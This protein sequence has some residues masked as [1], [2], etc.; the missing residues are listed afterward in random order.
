MFEPHGDGGVQVKI[1]LKKCQW[2]KRPTGL[3]QTGKL[4]MMR[5]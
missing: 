5:G 1:L 4:G 3:L 2:F